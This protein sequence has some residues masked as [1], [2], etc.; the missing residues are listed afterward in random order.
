MASILPYLKGAAQRGAGDDEVYSIQQTSDGGYIVAGYTEP[1]GAGYWD[2][3]VLKLDANGN[4]FGCTPGDIV[5]T[6]SV[7]PAA[8]SA[9]PKNTSAASPSSSASTTD[10]NVAPSDTS[11]S[12]QV[13]CTG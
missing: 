12:I 6:S 11:A 8:S 9:I 4:I 5:Q 7:A 3:W 13:Q 2:I 1:F 10:T